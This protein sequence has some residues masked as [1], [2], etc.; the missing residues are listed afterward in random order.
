M[1]HVKF[2]AKVQDSTI[3][4]FPKKLKRTQ[5]NLHQ[6]AIGDEYAEK[7]EQKDVIWEL[8][9]IFVGMMKSI[10]SMPLIHI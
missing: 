5:E 1:K 3:W 6:Q 9:T 4:G 2:S 7:R 8:L 10:C